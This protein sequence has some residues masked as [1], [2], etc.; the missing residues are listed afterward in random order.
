MRIADQRQII[1]ECLKH[2]AYIRELKER[3]IRHYE[4]MARDLESET[5]LRESRKLALIT[6]ESNNCKN[7]EARAQEDQ[8]RAEFL[9]SSLKII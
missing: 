1:L 5:K 8:A 3:E 6:H 4:K 9:K 7:R 2:E